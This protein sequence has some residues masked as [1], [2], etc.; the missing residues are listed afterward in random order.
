M[1][2]MTTQMFLWLAQL[3][4]IGAVSEVKN[5]FNI[6]GGIE[7]IDNRINYCCTESLID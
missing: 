2:H 5:V 6:S 3:T 4:A 1:L 7:E